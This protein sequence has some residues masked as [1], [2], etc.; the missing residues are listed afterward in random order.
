MSLNRKGIILAGG[1]GKRLRP[2]TT[3]VSKQLMPVY[4]K[5]M[6][7]YPLTTL[8]LAGIREFLIITN[9][10]HLSAFQRIL[11]DGNQWGL[12]ISYAVQKEPN[13][14]AEAFLIGESFLNNHPSALILGDNLFHSSEMLSLLKKAND[15]KEGCTI[16]TYRVKDPENYGVVKIDSNSLPIEI[17]EKPSEFIS[18][19]AITGLYFYDADVV[20][21]AKLIKPSKRNELEISSI[22]DSYLKEGKLKIYSF[23]RGTAWL[24][25]GNFD[26]LHHASSYI[27]TLEMRTGLKI[28]SPEEVAWR[29]GWITS[30]DLISLAK[31][32]S[33]SGYGDYLI[34]LIS[35]LNKTK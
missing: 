26:S 5:P 14:I 4:D 32:C 11:L 2:L 6:L 1:N 10:E 28:G 20:S 24:D 7:Y 13:G 8:M 19:Y 27:R 18:S 23:N 34:N 16:F 31:D 21:K 9:E 33:Q 25:T 30:K 15:Q 12:K 35:E 3:S 22:N 29:Q 17:V